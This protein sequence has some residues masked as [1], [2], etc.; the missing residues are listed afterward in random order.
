MQPD[1]HRYINAAWL[2]LGAVWLAGALTAK[3]AVRTEGAV[4]RLVHMVPLVVAMT[5]VFSPRW[6]VG[7]LAWRLVPESAATAYAGLALTLA[8]VAFA[9]WARV[10]LGGNW[11]GSVT[12][13]ENHTLVR[14]GPYRLVRH[15]IYTGGLL[16]FLGTAVYYGVLGG[17]AGT[18]IASLS[19]WLKSRVE[20]SFMTEQFGAQ[21]ERYQREV[22]RL[23]PFVL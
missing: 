8:G 23:I 5:M 17:L 2:A 20:E 16:G 14:R 18:A 4:S 12:V 3:R 9:M 10:A 22:K 15:P 11:S 21:Y 19:F 13:K 1:L 7:L 6:R